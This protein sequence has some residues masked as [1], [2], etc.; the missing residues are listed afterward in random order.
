MATGFLPIG[1]AVAFCAL[2]PVFAPAQSTETYEQPPISYS[3]TQPR[4]RMTQVRARLAE[5]KINLSGSGKDVVQTLLRELAI[6]VESQVLVFSKTSFQRELI[7]PG[8][9][10][11]IYFSDSSYVG[12]VP[13]GQVEIATMDPTLGPIFYRFNPNAAKPEFVRD[14]ECLSCHGGT[15]VRGIPG[16]FVRSVFTDATGEPLLRHGSEVVD[17]RTPFTNRWGGWY[18]TG[19][20]G[21]SLHRGNVPAREEKD[22]L[23]TDFKR[24]ANRTNLN[25]FFDTRQ[26]LT[27]GS[28]LVALLV[29]EH[30]LTMQNTLT[31]AALDCRRMLVYQKNLQRDLKEPVTDELIYDSVKRVFE[32]AAR[33]IV[34][35]L[36]FKDEALLPN[37]L[38]GAAAFQAAFQHGVPRAQDGSSLKDFRLEQHLFRNRCSYLIYS[39]CFL[40]LPEQL[41]R[42]VYARLIHALRRKNPDLQYAYLDDAERAR[43]NHILR[44]THPEFQKAINR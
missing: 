15:F 37:G 22:A 42:L 6:P 43:I 9:P 1:L 21:V 11:A 41:K 2:H 26:Y 31:R 44:Q 4:D 40:A 16:V 29:L 32:S 27:Q 34:N 20:H 14:S 25:E 38:Q 17:V 23:L 30:Q 13:Y 36:L 28:D 35:D 19:K 39:E 10:R 18:V 33:E 3:T 12:W 24:G 8:R 7:H 5:G